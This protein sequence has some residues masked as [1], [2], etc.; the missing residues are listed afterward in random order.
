M[1]QIAVNPLGFPG[2]TGRSQDAMWW[3]YVK[4]VSVTSTWEDVGSK[5]KG[6]RRPIDQPMDGDGIVVPIVR[7][8][9]ECRSVPVQDTGVVDELRGGAVW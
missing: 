3:A 5:T 9:Q 4:R 1:E 2:T 7:E 8:N 6:Y